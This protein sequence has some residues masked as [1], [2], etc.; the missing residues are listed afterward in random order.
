MPLDKISLKATIKTIV[1]DLFANTSNL[2]PAQARNKFATDLA[3]AIDVYVKGG[4]V[5]TN[6]GPTTQTGSVT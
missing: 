3:D 4:L 5:I 6:G 1:D 2:S